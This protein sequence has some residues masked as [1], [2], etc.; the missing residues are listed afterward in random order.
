M[1]TYKTWPA[2]ETKHFPSLVQRGIQSQTNHRDT[3]VEA[4]VIVVVAPAVWSPSRN[5]GCV[6]R[7]RYENK[8]EKP[9]LC[10][11]KKKKL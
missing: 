2:N 1:K 3:S 6:T 11:L 5:S 7:P 9:E 10:I 4:P 8:K